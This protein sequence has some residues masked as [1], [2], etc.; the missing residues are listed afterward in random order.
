M[1]LRDRK[2]LNYDVV[3]NHIFY[4]FKD[5]PQVKKYLKKYKKEKTL[6]PKEMGYL[7]EYFTTPFRQ[8]DL[9]KINFEMYYEYTKKYED[10]NVILPKE[11]RNNG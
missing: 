10:V 4:V 8:Y 6:P 5:E 11:L 2:Y 7:L 1:Y 3:K 9:P